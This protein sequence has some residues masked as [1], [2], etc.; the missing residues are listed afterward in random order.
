MGFGLPS[1]MGAQLAFPNRTVVDIDGDG[2]FLMNIQELQT[3][4]QEKIPVKCLVLN[5]QYLGMVAQWEDRF[6]ESVRGHTFLGEANFAEIAKAFGLAG[7][8]IRKPS[9]VEPALKKM[10]AHKGPYVLDVKYPYDDKSHGHVIPMIPGGKTYLDS[11]INTGTN[12]R[13]YWK[14]KGILVD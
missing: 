10:L 2:S 9:E 13:D 14:E 1:A 4:K 12:L 11:I 6:Y 5:N 3:L 7:D 8:T